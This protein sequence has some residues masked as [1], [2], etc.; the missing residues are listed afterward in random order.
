MKITSCANPLAE[1]R[2]HTTFRRT[3]PHFYRRIAAVA[4]LWLAHAAAIHAASLQVTVVDR[5]GKPL[6][7]AV[8]IVVPAAT[9]AARGAA[10]SPPPMQA[11]IN[12]EKMQ[13][14]PAVTVVAPGAKVRFVNSDAWDH[15]VRLSAPGLTN[16]GTAAAPE[17][18]AMRME[19]KTEGKPAKSV[20]VTLDKAGP[21]GA[22]LLG[23]YIHGSMSGHV[24][25]A[26]SPWALKTG[27]DGAVAM[28]DLPDGAATVQVWHPLLT[29]PPKLQPTTLGA[30]LGKLNVQLDVVPRR[31]RN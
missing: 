16:F 25:V 7:D 26:D 19:G 2:F 22:N 8:V 18:I 15:H 6:A 24:Y 5:E 21:L 1:P 10:K 17:G 28:D 31:R 14:V 3:Q 11:T 27:A 12:Q 4:C 29:V 20:E 23:C 13:F 30:A 9:G